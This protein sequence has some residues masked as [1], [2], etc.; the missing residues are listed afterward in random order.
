MEKSTKNHGSPGKGT[1][2]S[3]L[4]KQGKYVRGLGSQTNKMNVPTV[5][6]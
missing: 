2:K 5:E 1:L 6:A 4:G 3:V